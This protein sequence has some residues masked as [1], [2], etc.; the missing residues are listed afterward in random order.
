[1]GKVITNIDIDIS[2]DTAMLLKHRNIVF[3]YLMLGMKYLIS[4][5]FCLYLVYKMSN[6]FLSSEVHFFFQIFT[7]LIMIIYSTCKHICKIRRGMRNVYNSIY[8]LSSDQC[9]AFKVHK[10]F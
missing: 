5:K 7:T 3:R 10:M 4:Y 8:W 2:S 9:V 1:M 6:R